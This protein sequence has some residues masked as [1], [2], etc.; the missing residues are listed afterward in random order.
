MRDE[1]EAFLK[2][3]VEAP[4][5]SGFEQ[6][7]ARVFR[8]YVGAFADE[9]TTDVLGSVH[10][11]LE[12]SADGP[13]VMLA[14]HMDEIGFMVNYITDQGFLAFR[15]I[16]GIDAH[17]LPGSRVIVHTKEGPVPGVM[18]RLPV[19]L[20]DKDE[21]TKVAKVHKLFIDVGMGADRVKE[22]VRV[23]DPITFAAGFEEIGDG[24][25]VS[26]GFDDKIGAWV[27]AETLRLVK[28]TGG[29]SGD[30]FAVATV[31]EEIGGRGATTST[32]HLDPDVGVAVE[33]THATDYPDVDKRR[34]G[35]VS[36]GSGPVITRGANVNPVVF[37]LLVETAEAVD[38]P[39][40]VNGSPG[41]TPTDAD[42]MQLARSGRA[43]ALVS[44][45]LRYMHTPT[46]VV[47]LVDLE[48]T[49]QLLATFVSRLEPGTDFTP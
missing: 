40:Q 36:L 17:L 2:E 43:A 8:D 31:M 45:P 6:P 32:Y 37:D 4:S 14:G 11:R 44:V 3:F 21:R 46:E 41:K 18:G 26:R 23:G 1:S 24:L 42:P 5:P 12:G 39:Y 47:S 48:S 19:H 10:A 35:D 33:V 15:T 13:S 16:G 49:A 34:C 38:I 7:A 20:L 25:A 9:V 30:L 27:A 22:T 28:E 29:S